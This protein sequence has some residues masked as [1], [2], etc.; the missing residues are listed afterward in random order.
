MQSRRRLK[1]AFVLLMAAGLMGGVALWHSSEPPLN[2]EERRL[3]GTWGYAHNRKFPQEFRADGIFINHSVGTHGAFLHWKLR[4]GRLK[5]FNIISGNR[6]PLPTAF[7]NCV[8]RVPVLSGLFCQQSTVA[9][10]YHLQ[11]KGNDEV[12]FHTTPESDG[13]NLSFSF[14][15]VRIP[16]GDSEAIDAGPAKPAP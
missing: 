15:L 9:A 5:L 3:I 11:W 16:A 7:Y 6:V 13:T 12:E 10:C 2:A 8:A 4:D 1:L 14:T